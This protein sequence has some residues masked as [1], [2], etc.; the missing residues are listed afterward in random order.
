M[1]TWA[2]PSCGGENAQEMRFCG[3]CGTPLTTPSVS[4]EERRVVTA[5]FTD[6]VGSTSRGEELDPEDVRAM[7]APYYARLRHE[8]ELYGGVVE[9]FIG[10]AV[11]ALFGA[12]VSHEDDPERA[13][14]AALAIGRAIS[15]LN[16]SDPWLD[17]H[18]RTAV[19][20]GEALVVL[21]ARVRE[22]EGMAAG[23]V[24][25][26]AARL[27]SAAP[28]NGIVVGEEAYR[29]TR[30]IVVYRELEPVPAKGKAEPVRVWE[31]VALE[32]DHESR[33]AETPLVG[34]ARELERI[35]HHWREV[36][37]ERAR[38]LITVV[39]PPG[40]GKSRLLAEFTTA[41]GADGAVH[42]G[43]CLPYG[44]GITYWP[45]TELIKSAANILQ[46]D[47][48]ETSLAKLGALLDGLPTTKQ[49]ELRTMAAALSNLLGIAT[50]PRS[51][52]AAGE[53]SQAELHWGVRRLFE[54]L[55]VQRPLLI[56]LEDLHW[57]EPTLL[58][59]V[60]FIVEGSS[61]AR[62][63]I[64]ASGRP[65]LLEA[66]HPV[67]HIESGFRVE[68]EA[69]EDS[70][71]RRLLETAVGGIE[72]PA[73]LVET[74]LENAAGNPLFIE[75]LAR[76]L[77]DEGLLGPDAATAELESL[78]VPAN[79]QA[80]IGSRLDRL[81]S[82]AK[83]IVQHAAIAG[84]VFWSG[85]VA[86][87]SGS[88]GD[89]GQSLA[90]LERRDLI[91]RHEL[92]SVEGEAEYAFKHVL[93][94]DVAYSR[95][96]KGRRVELHSRFADWVSALPGAEEEFVEIVAY[97][98]EQS[99]RLAR[100]IARSPIEP[101]IL[102]AVAALT[103]AA[104]KAERREG[105]REAGRYY[106]RALELVELSHPEA[107]L[108]V[109]VRYGRS[110][111]G[112]GE[113]RR[114][115]EELADAAEQAIGFG[116]PDLR[117]RALVTLG[118]IDHRQ[119][120]AAD[121]RSHLTEAHAIAGQIGDPAIQIRA[122]FGF[123]AL[124]AD[125][126]SAPEEAAEELRNAIAVAEEIDDRA[127][128]VE[129]HLRLAFLLF[130]MGDLVE[131]ERELLRCVELASEHGSHRDEARATFLLGLARYYRGELEEAERLNLQARDWLERTCEAYFQMQNFRALGV[132]ALARD[133]PQEAERWL[134]EAMPIALEEDG[135]YVLEVYRYLTEALAFQGRVDDASA[136]AEF[137]A[138]NVPEEDVA[139]QA[140]VVLAAAAVAAERDDREA[141]R[142]SY[143]Q[144]I[145]WL[146]E[147]R[148]PLEA[149]E[150]R[151]TFAR[152]LRR[153]GDMQ[154]ARSQLTLAR[155]TLESAAATG[156]VAVIERELEQLGSGAGDA[157]PARSR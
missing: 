112:V 10:D 138:R 67:T 7:L 33:S 92:S 121:A 134:R 124:K 32:E 107:A 96:P 43:R 2:C 84:N 148:L 36:R 69:L 90:E 79:L 156:L 15:E 77:A 125:F 98:L 97:H 60:R 108:E 23:D 58:D 5:V 113:V 50:T 62:L 20:T 128:R 26:T 140:Y 139:A 147:Q 59:L 64:L 99:C 27:Q 24:M 72:L 25:N 49:D 133:E 55:A 116:R 154:E 65:E 75:E 132:Y 88:N 68:V 129:G 149:G 151:V 14:R 152:A 101:P 56:V 45:V 53:I 89:L 119:G 137:A 141:A 70:E 130:N 41:S 46:S 51:T 86:E 115:C 144:A 17:L 21:D 105:W 81:P 1:S 18:I 8:L 114:A 66:D 47:D 73:S 103:R 127:L 153:F 71:S 85:A 102:P 87:L 13:V 4:E 126:E 80:L 78:P 42:T 48:A 3:H 63:L 57:A 30:E 6:L 142:R 37:T 74:V 131:S 157:G 122:A 118:H 109:R 100:E 9:K 155:D 95:L 110:L 31:V 34:R 135:R 111:A 35:R 104:D 83:R 117:C 19:N 28:V 82:A 143:A 12:P 120:R 145:G 38:R 94:R 44:E 40:I 39:G 29:A 150:A 93:I 123:S 106:V 91:R 16:E 76:M 52:Y 22:G 61:P 136:L 11:V 54:L 146:E